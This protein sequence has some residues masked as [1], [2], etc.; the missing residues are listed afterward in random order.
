MRRFGSLARVMSL[1]SP[2]TRR[3]L[4]RA[5]VVLGPA[6]LL[7]PML[8]GPAQALRRDDGDDPG[9][10]LSTLEV[11]L[12]FGVIPIAVMGLIALLVCLPSL[13][14]SPR[15]TAGWDGRS[16]WLGGPAQQPA[17]VGSGAAPD[18]RTG[19]PDVL[20][21]SPDALTGTVVSARPRR[22]AGDPEE[23]GGGGS[24]ARW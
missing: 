3:P 7:G 19:S 6:V 23:S 17:A 21:G 10:Q 24:S 8:A 1:K 16:A 22:H 14:K 13:V 12:I 11:L 5:G 15:G 9:E 4:A 18:A 20:T 2:R